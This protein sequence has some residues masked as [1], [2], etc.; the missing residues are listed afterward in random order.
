[1][2]LEWI[3]SFALGSTS[4]LSK[5]GGGFWDTAIGGGGNG[6]F[7]ASGSGRW[8]GTTRYFSLTQNNSYIEK[9]FTSVAT[10]CVG[11]A[12]QF[13][14]MGTFNF[15]FLRL[16]DGTTLQVEVRATTTGEI[17]VLRNTTQIGITSGLGLLLGNWYYFEAKVTINSSTGAVTIYKNGTAILTLT[18]VNTQNSTNA[19]QDRVR[20]SSIASNTAS[21]TT[22]FCDLYILNTSGATNNDILGEC[23]VEN[24]LPSGAGTTTQFTPSTG[25]NYQNVDDSGTPD[26]DSTYNEDA[27]LNDIDLY[28]MG[29]LASSSGAV[30]GACIKA[31]AKRTDVSA[32]T[33]GLGLRS[34]STNDFDAGQS[35]NSSYGYF[36]RL[37]DQNP[38]TAADFT[39]SEI[40]AI[41]VGLKVVL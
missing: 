18:G 8:G 3:D 41:E 29:N 26:D 9:I 38:V 5:A 32:K 16:Y 25:S 10:R 13:Q 36:A 27:T 35:V 30:K 31:W 21:H 2:S 22:Y 11:V 33:I 12:V 4:Q 15:P 20:L 14:S 40:N 1:M 6:A 23:R 24:L 17:E 7:G 28:A 34:G 19:T 39:Y 37:M